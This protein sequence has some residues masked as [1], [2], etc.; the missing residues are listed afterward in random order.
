V[1]P[2]GDIQL[3]W[4]AATVVSQLKNPE[5]LAGSWVVESSAIGTL[6]LA[7]MYAAIP[8]FMALEWHAGG[9]PFFQ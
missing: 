6:A 5:P 9:V 8:D 4:L 1:S 2:G 3:E 7:H